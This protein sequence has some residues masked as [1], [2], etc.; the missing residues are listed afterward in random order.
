[1]MKKYT[2]YKLITIMLIAIFLSTSCSLQIATDEGKPIEPLVSGA[3]EE[4]NFSVGQFTVKSRDVQITDLAVTAAG[5]LAV[6]ATA[7]KEVY[8]LGEDGKP[9]WENQ[10]D[11]VPLQTYIADDGSFVAIGTEGG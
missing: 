9:L 4:S 2:K 6:V 10:Q 5:D 8:M 11:T 1:M 3:E 7:A